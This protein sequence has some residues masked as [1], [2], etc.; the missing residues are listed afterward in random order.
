LYGELADSFCTAPLSAVV[1]LAAAAVVVVAAASLLPSSPQAAM[2]ADAAATTAATLPAFTIR[3]FPNE[4][5]VEVMGS[6][7]PS[8]GRP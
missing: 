8:R 1:A 2:A 6:I 4:V 3:L 7:L 5:D